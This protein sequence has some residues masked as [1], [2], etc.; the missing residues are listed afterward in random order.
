MSIHICND[1]FSHRSLKI[2]KENISGSPSGPVCRGMRASS[3]F[4]DSR[5]PLMMW[6]K[7]CQ[8]INPLAQVWLG[9]HVECRVVVPSPAPPYLFLF[10]VVVN[11]VYLKLNKMICARRNAPSKYPPW[12]ASAKGED[13]VGANLVKVKKINP[14]RYGLC[15]P[16]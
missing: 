11:R 16:F 12:A 6:C 5:G 8:K 2:G 4:R 3:S 9:R 10:S 14:G 1:V 7:P 13:R 15:N